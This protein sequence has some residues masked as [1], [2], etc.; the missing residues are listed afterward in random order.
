VMSVLDILGWAAMMNDSK[1][2]WFGQ[3]R[4]KINP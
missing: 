1:S 3:S 2:L 4:S